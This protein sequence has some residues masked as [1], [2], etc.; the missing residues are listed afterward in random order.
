[1]ELRKRKQNRLRDFDYSQPGAYFITICTADRKNL[2]WQDVGAII[3][4]P[5]S[6]ALTEYGKIVAQAIR[7][8]PKY[9]DAVSVDSYVIMPNHIH[10]L[11]Q[12]NTDEDGRLIT[13]PTIST[14]V[15]QVKRVASKQVGVSLWQK[16]FY[17]HVV[18]SEHDYQEI[19]EYIRDNPVKWLED[20]LYTE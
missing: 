2:F 8:I 15:R 11:L 18:R 9:Y 5:E 1:M 3:N 17:D 14:V 12:I 16:G 20:K 7:D 4:R 6:P 13:A 10:L 19:W